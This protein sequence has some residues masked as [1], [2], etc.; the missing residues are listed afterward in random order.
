[1]INKLKLKFDKK[2]DE[3]LSFNGD[4]FCKEFDELYYELFDLNSKMMKL[5]IKMQ[6][7]QYLMP[8]PR[9]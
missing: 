3:L 6:K 1:M 2:Y 9:I 7:E 8:E 5:L 4:P